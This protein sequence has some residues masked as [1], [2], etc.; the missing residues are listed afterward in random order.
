MPARMILVLDHLRNLGDHVAA[1]LDLHPVAD[2]HA[3]PL[4]LV[5]VVQRGVADGRSADQH[6][7]QHRP[8]A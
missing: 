1:A 8:R 2:L 5:H 7:R 4:D 6:R 3:Q